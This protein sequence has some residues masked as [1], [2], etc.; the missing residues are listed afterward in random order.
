[1]ATERECWYCGRQGRRGF[2]PLAG[3][4]AWACRR[5]WWC[6]RRLDRDYDRRV[7]AKRASVEQELRDSGRWH[8]PWR[9]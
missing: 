9:S 3:G 6:M 4:L 8:G 5:T 2:R 7:K 1:M